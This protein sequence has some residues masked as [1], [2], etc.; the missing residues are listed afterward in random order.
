MALT[1]LQQAQDI[2]K[3]SSSIIIVLPR[4]PS[5]DAVASGLGLFLVV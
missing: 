3:K 5:V 2:I 4:N 1:P